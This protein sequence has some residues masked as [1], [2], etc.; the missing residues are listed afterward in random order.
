MIV[1]KHSAILRRLVELSPDSTLLKHYLSLKADTP[2]VG[3]LGV[4]C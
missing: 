1:R 2:A 4:L 3:V